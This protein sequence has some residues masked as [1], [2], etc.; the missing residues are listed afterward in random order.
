MR[1]RG[2]AKGVAS[3]WDR[4]NVDR[5]TD[6]EL[7]VIRLLTEEYSEASQVA[8]LIDRVALRMALT[9]QNTRF[10]MN[11][12]YAIRVTVIASGVLLPAAVT[13]ESQ[14]HG[15]AHTWLSA[16]AIALA[17][18]LAV[19]AGILQMTKID[20]QARLS[21]W[22]WIELRNEAWALA[23]C[24]GAYTDPSPSTRFGVFVDRVELLLHT[25][26]SGILTVLAGVSGDP[27]PGLPPESVGIA[28]AN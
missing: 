17:V 5:H 25:F 6:Q 12:F 1:R 18:T 26:E 22:A 2:S 21:H 19:A 10:A 27:S 3:N 4:V 23:Q 15:T 7:K 8:Y 14:S 24:R 20:Q 28:P 13:A 9:H 11:F 16:G